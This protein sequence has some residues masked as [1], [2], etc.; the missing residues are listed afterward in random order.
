M[1]ASWLA[2]SCI[3]C[4]F[5]IK[6]FAIH[7]VAG[8]KTKTIK[9]KIGIDLMMAS[10]LDEYE[11]S[12]NI[13]QSAQQH[14]RLSSANIGITHSGKSASS[15]LLYNECL[16]SSSFFSITLLTQTNMFPCARICECKTWGGEA[17]LQQAEDWLYT[18]WEDK[19]SRCLQQPAVH[20]PGKGH[21][22]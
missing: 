9:T 14:S 7:S 17:D 20:E 13:R 21:S 10:I 6:V 18:T 3:L 5:G 1:T 16:G 11:D 8:I 2:T 4:R 22:A 12:Q 15:T 19:P